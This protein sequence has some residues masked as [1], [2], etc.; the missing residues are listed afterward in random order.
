MPETRRKVTLPNIGVVEGIDVPVKETTE[1]WSEVVLA[2]GTTLR[3]KPNVLTVTRVDG[4]YDN[5]G[6][7]MYALQSGQIM[8]VTNVPAHLRKPAGGTKAN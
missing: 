6:N 3:L 4:H 5:E 8:T 1:R 7:P 2:D